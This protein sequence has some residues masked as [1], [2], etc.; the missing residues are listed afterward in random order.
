MTLLPGAAVFGTDE[1]F[2]QI[3]G[4]HLDLIVLGGLQVSKT[5]D[6]ASWMVPVSS[7]KVSH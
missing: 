3:R 6:L 2:A 5:G 4:G 1:A 7:K